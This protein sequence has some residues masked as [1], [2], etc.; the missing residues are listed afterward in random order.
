MNKK[1][2]L[3]DTRH[4]VDGGFRTNTGQN[5]ASAAGVICDQYSELGNKSP[6]PGEFN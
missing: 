3:P 6:R 5:I 2:R 1:Y 4:E